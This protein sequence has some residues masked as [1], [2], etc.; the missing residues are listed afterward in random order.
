[1]N[2][3]II[4]SNIQPNKSF[5][6]IFH[7]A[8]IH[9]PNE[10]NRH[11][12]FRLVFSNLY[13]IIKS[14]KTQ[15]SLIVICGD[16]I[17]KSNKISPECINLV[18]NFFYQ[19]SNICYTIIISGNHDD[20]IRGNDLKIDS[21]TSIIN[22]LNYP[23][24]FYFRDTGVYNVGDNITFALTSVFDET[25]IKSNDYQTDRLKIALYHGMVE[26]IDDNKNHLAKGDYQFT[27][28][29]FNGYDFVLLGDIHNFNY[30]NKNKTIAYP[31]SLIQ[32]S[33]GED[34]NT[35]GGLLEW[36]LTN[37]SSNFINIPNNY[38]YITI[39]YK[40]G[41]FKIPDYYPQN[42]RIRIKYYDEYKPISEI[43]K[44]LKNQLTCN[45]E[46]LKVQYINQ[47]QNTNIEN[48]INNQND[49]LD[50]LTNDLRLD[51]IVKD[52][53]Y[54]IH[55]KEIKN[56]NKDIE[57]H[58]SL[59][60]IKKLEF[61]NILCFSKKQTLDFNTISIKDNLCGIL[62]KNAQG[63]SS[64]VLVIIYSLFGS[65]PGLN[66]DDLK[67][68][69]NSN[70][71]LKTK[72]SF[73]LINHNYLIE[74]T[75]KTVKL[76]KDSI[77]ISESSK[78]ETES[79]ITNLIGDLNVIKNTNVSLQEQH[80]N[81]INSNN[82]DKFKIVKKILGI[83]IYDE[84][85]NN[86]KLKIKDIEEEYND[87]KKET[88]KKELLKNTKPNLLQELESLNNQ[89]VEYELKKENNN[90]K[91]IFDKLNT[92]TKKYNKN[93]EDLL[94]NIESINNKLKE[95]D[96]N[97]LGSKKE[98]LVEELE[99]NSKKISEL[100]K[101]FIPN[102][103]NIIIEDL[104][105]KKD[106]LEK[107]LGENLENKLQIEQ[108][109][110]Q[111][112]SIV[113]PNN[114]QELYNSYIKD[115]ELYTKCNSNIENINSN[116]I[117]KN[118][119]IQKHKC[120]YNLQCH[121][122]LYNKK[123]N[124]LEDL[125]LEYKELLKEKELVE[126]QKEKLGRKIK[127]YN[128]IEEDYNKYLT[129]QPLK[130]ELNKKLGKIELTKERIEFEIEKNNNDLQQES[131]INTNTIIEKE[132]EELEIKNKQI[133]KDISNITKK[134]GENQKYLNQLEKYNSKLDEI[135]KNIISND[136]E[137]KE[138]NYV[139]EDYDDKLLIE[140]Y[141]NIGQIEY[142][143]EEIKDIDKTLGVEL[144]NLKELE[145][146]LKDY[147]LYY[148]ITN[149]K[150]FP[151]Y[152]INK[153]VKILENEINKI[154]GNIVD[155]T[156]KLELVNDGL[157]KEDLTFY[158]KDNILIP[159]KNCSG[160]EKFIFSIA[161]RIGLINISNYMT[162]NFIIIDEG[163]GS[164]DDKNLKKIGDVFGNIKNSFDLILIITHKEELKEELK[165]VINLNNYRI[166]Y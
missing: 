61:E 30:L 46:E 35:H 42:P 80:N 102:L 119:L 36:N 98:S 54:N 63:K 109:L 151:I 18:K 22:D 4:D 106:E 64:L 66:S 62:G 104:Y 118:K 85:N 10:T 133:N 157:K 122:C 17:N 19:L 78:R 134:L 2:L 84:I 67:N 65:V 152:L 138:L 16:I 88:G 146:E 132:L 39:E 32:L 165:N 153:K 114:L 81:L 137:L 92:N 112:N 135:Q 59:W 13:Q 52:N 91:S 96:I 56:L 113:L 115:K 158:K 5:T 107:K 53:I 40:D 95:Y 25:L 71:H 83:D 131:N 75:F 94:D 149:W 26:A 162:P 34:I 6:K 155:F 105:I 127:S 20:N 130:E 47:N 103:T 24:L 120:R 7:I 97:L 21:I 123:Q 68:K 99:N 1:M 74:R 86:I 14:K 126:I 28:K 41:L 51:S 58:K 60:K 8:D 116:I 90:K 43:E 142:K 79:I 160:F 50:Y 73:S 33:H 49:F 121:D 87:L 89:R 11:E 150:G 166:S 147:K 139:I 76:Y 44:S 77:N 82:S 31:G 124:G 57:L 148:K 108:E 164:M 154:L 29:D 55:K 37:G 72:I 9:I 144:L 136:G 3:K 27:T 163:F 70:K 93:K 128:D 23:N 110:L 140:L 143:L 125:E 15:D 145:R 156:C 38:G 100:Q 141:K 12:E 45:I 161:I 159:V 101:K 48:H 111:L 129:T 69:H 117:K